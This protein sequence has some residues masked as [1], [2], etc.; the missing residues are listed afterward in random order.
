[1]DDITLYYLL[2]TL[3]I[4]SF[5]A[6]M[7]GMFYLPRL[8]VYHTKA[9]KGGELDLTL[10]TMERRLLKAIMTPAMIATW[11]FGLW[12]ASAYDFFSQ[13]GW[14]GAKMLCVLL[15]SGCHGLFAVHRKAFLHGTN[16]KSESY[17][18]IINEVPTILLIIIV[19]LAVFKPF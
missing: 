4:I 16:E 8:Y 14:L 17:F 15:M 2:R 6:W 13:G 7:A 19:S 9:T 3:H 10:Q 5:V 18:R 11:V 1:M 12:L